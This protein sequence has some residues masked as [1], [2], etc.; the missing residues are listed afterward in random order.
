MIHSALTCCATNWSIQVGPAPHSG[1]IHCIATCCTRRMFARCLTLGCFDFVHLVPNTTSPE[2]LD[3]YRHS[4]EVQSR[5]PSLSWFLRMQH[6]PILR[7]HYCTRRHL[8]SF[9]LRSLRSFF[10]QHDQNA[11]QFSCD[12]TNQSLID[13]H[14]R[15]F[16][17]MDGCC[18]VSVGL[19]VFVHVCQCSAKESTRPT[20]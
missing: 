15:E 18:F 17:V 10:H 2:L 11:V 1:V 12:V 20:G 7:I 19:D 14:Q 9:E 13:F 3:G 16:Q 8:S 6:C 4:D 5:N